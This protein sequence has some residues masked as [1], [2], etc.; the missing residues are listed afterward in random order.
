LKYAGDH[1][2]KLCLKARTL[3]PSDTVRHAAEMMDRY[4]EGFRWS[5]LPLARLPAISAER[6][7]ARRHRLDGAVISQAKKGEFLLPP[8]DSIDAVRSLMT[9]EGLG[10]AGRQRASGP[11]VAS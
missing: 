1:Q 9:S 11:V 4:D 6:L 3:A 10:S 7:T 8:G 5:T 2:S